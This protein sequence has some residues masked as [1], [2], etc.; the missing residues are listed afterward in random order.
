[1]YAIQ[2][3]KLTKTYRDTMAVNG[4]NLTVREG[5]LFGLLGLN[6]AGKTTTIKM[7]SCLIKLTK[8]DATVLGSSVIHHSMKVKRKEINVS[9][10]GGRL[11]P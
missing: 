11:L 9:P 5:E 6:G 1:M 3:E 8:G 4:L 2:T 7:L 10:Q